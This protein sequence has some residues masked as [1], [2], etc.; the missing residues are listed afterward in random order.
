MSGK[1]SWLSQKSVQVFT[2]SRVWSQRRTVILPPRKNDNDSVVAPGGNHRSAP[3]SYP[4]LKVLYF[5]DNYVVV[6]KPPDLRM[7]GDFK[8]NLQ[9][10]IANCFA[11]MPCPHPCHQ[12]DYATSGVML[13]AFNSSAA[14][15]ACMCFTSRTAIKHYIAIVDGHVPGEAAGHPKQI[16]Y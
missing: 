11:N 15:R 7:D 6:D 10:M 5:D 3:L 4:P 14:K 16:I 8:F 12:L 1:C 13:W 2:C 9:R